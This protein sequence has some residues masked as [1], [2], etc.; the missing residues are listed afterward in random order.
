MKPFSRFSVP[1]SA[2]L[3]L[4]ALATSAWAVPLRALD[5]GLDRATLTEDSQYMRRIHEEKSRGASTEAVAIDLADPNQYRFVLNRLK[6]SGKTA[7]NAPKLFERLGLAREKALARQAGKQPEAL[8]ITNWGCDHFLSLGRGV[9]SGSLRTYK[10]NPWAACLNGASY[11]YTDIVAFNSNMPETENLIVDSA[12]GEEFAAGQSFDDVIVNPAIPTNLDRQ[13]VLDSMMIAMNENTGEEV[14]TY[15]R[16]QTASTPGAANLTIIHPR[17]AGAAKP[18]TE[19]CQMRGG[20]DCDY[21]AAVVSGS[22]LAPAGPA[23]PTSVAMRNTAITTSWVGDAANNFPTTETWVNTNVYVPTQFTFNAGSRNSIN[24][25]VKSI[26]KDSSKVRLVKTVTGGTCMTQQVIG[27]QLDGGIGQNTFT[28]KL[29]ANMTRETSIPGTGTENCNAQSIINQAVEYVITVSTKVTCGTTAEFPATVTVRLKSDDRYQYGVMVWNSCM[30]EG[31]KVVLADGTIVPVE[32]VKKG[33]K[34]VTNAKGDMLTVTDVQSGGE[35][36][37]MVNLR[38]DKGHAVS[39]TEKHPVIL[40]NGKA[41][42][43]SA[44]KVNDRVSTRDGDA[45]LTQIT[46]TKY[47]G[48]VYNFNLGTPA[49]LAK[50]GKDANT[51][52]ANGIRVGDNAMQGDMSAP[53]ADTRAILERLPTVWHQD[54]TQSPS[55]VAGQ[56]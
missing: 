51:L 8:A 49:E 48:K 19:L 9:P 5:R 31:T 40:A 27:S 45:T 46:R 7:A 16:A 20:M 50:A 29:L 54:Y 21:A 11:V 41:V 12:S 24:C 28:P 43:A 37:L 36:D 26:N 32:A 6:G 22:S 15:L 47:T 23:T 35:K 10:S 30:A 38:D 34:L 53:V 3:P 2:A 1:V 14:V 39:L 52:F 25:V 44:L 18:N 4:V 55:F 17:L 33:D 13:L 56:R 42:F